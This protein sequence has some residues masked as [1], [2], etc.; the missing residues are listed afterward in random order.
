MNKIVK[1]RI[2][3]MTAGAAFLIFHFAFSSLHAYSGIPS[4]GSIRGVYISGK[5]PSHL[6]EGDVGFWEGVVSSMTWQLPGACWEKPVN[7]I[8]GNTY[9]YKYALKYGT[10]AVTTLIW[11][12]TNFW[13]SVYVGY[14]DNVYLDG[15]FTK[16]ISASSVEDNWAGAPSPPQDPVVDVGDG[17]ADITWAVPHFGGMNLLDT[18]GFLVYLSTDGSQWSNYNDT[19]SLISP[20]DT[21]VRISNLRNN[22]GYY[23]KLRSVD[24]YEYPLIDINSEL[25]PAA[26]YARNFRWSYSQMLYFKPNRKISCKFSL[27]YPGNEDVF[28][29]L[30]GTD[31]RISREGDNYTAWLTL[32]EHETYSYH[33]KAGGVTD[34]YGTRS[35]KVIDIN[36]DGEFFVSDI[37]GIA[38]SDSLPEAIIGWKITVSTEDVDFLWKTNSGYSDN[39]TVYYSTDIL[40][41][42]VVISTNYSSFLWD[43]A[44]IGRTYYFAIGDSGHQSAPQEVDTSMISIVK[45]PP[46][47][48]IVEMVDQRVKTEVHMNDLKIKCSAP[49]KKGDEYA[50]TYWVL[51]STYN[52]NIVHGTEIDWEVNDFFVK[53][54]GVSPGVNI[55]CYSDISGATPLETNYIWN[56]NIFGSSETY[57]SLPDIYVTPVEVTR[58][59]GGDFSKNASVKFPE[60]SLPVKRGYLTIYNREE[61]SIAGNY[62][63]LS[64]KIDAANARTGQISYQREMSTSTIFMFNLT[65][66]DGSLLEQE[67]RRPVEI[68]LPYPAGTDTDNIAAFYLDEEYNFWKKVQ[69]GPHFEKP[70]INISSAAITFRTMHFSVFAL[71]TVA[72]EPDLSNAV[73]YPNPFKPFDKKF[74]T[75]AVYSAGNQYSGIHFTRLTSNTKIRIFTIDGVPVRSGLVSSNDGTCVWDARNDDG[76]DVSS[77]LYLI[78]AEDPNA[79]G[80]KKFIGKAAIIR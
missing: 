24:K 74:E 22:T 5:T 59:Y 41:W 58:R 7:L 3:C 1:M 29:V 13:H 16:S 45:I 67:F 36:N 78:L 28:L 38:N 26:S 21:N 61:V 55:E 70:E 15:D 9:Y 32:T 44:D 31:Y 77:G 4:S 20:D 73:I 30:G 50:D 52:L 19:C 69:I 6:K 35:V 80:E 63:E 33:Y 42:Y 48:K 8:P 54:T 53:K 47:L 34:P 39:V 65:K 76:R 72:G 64:S 27:N 62:R 18:K 71:M 37:W 46:P 51:K 11:E 49:V 57:C 17:F 12:Q 75:G 66:A 60:R 14:E 10:G 56:L 2:A 25:Y 79:L 23:L 43:D 40:N 68:T